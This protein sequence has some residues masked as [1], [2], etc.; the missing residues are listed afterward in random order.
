VVQYLNINGI[1][2]PDFDSMT[3]AE[4]NQ[5]LKEILP[6]YFV[7][8]ADID[9][10]RG[11]RLQAAIQ[12]HIDHS[13]SKTVNM[14]KGSTVEQV[15]EV[16]MLGWKLGLK[17][18]TVYVDGSRDG[19]LVSSSTEKKDDRPTEILHNISPK[20]P[21]TL[22]ADVY[23]VRVKGQLWGVVVG[24]L[25]GKPFEVF[26]GKSIELPNPNEVEYA[27]IKRNSSK[28]YSLSVK[29]KGNGIENIS[30]VQEIYD[31]E[32]QRQLTRSLCRELRHG[33]PVEFIVK[34][35]QENSGSLVEYSSA[36]ARVLK[37]YVTK[38]ELVLGNKKC[39]E[40]GGSLVPCDGCV[41]CGGPDGVKGGGCG[42]SKCQ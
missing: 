16:Y 41:S 4:A 34:D 6:S 20:R 19:V 14:P 25:K 37:K 29:I 24:L 31:E 17:G 7:T 23:Q 5:K 39:P 27:E 28:R 3:M 11:V 35:L 30:D 32:G 9:Y 13:I 15:Q 2:V 33:I 22:P 18:I 42:W 38:P 8:S 12:K 40:C 36:I 21:H 10:L 1:P 26:A